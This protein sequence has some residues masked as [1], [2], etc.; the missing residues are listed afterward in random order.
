MRVLSQEEERRISS[1]RKPDG[2]RLK[3]YD[4]ASG[5]YVEI[6][7]DFET[8]VLLSPV[9]FRARVGTYLNALTAQ[10]LSSAMDDLRREWN[11]ERKADAQAV[12]DGYGAVV[13]TYED[14]RATML[15]LADG[16]DD[17]VEVS[18][19]LAD[20][21]KVAGQTVDRYESAQYERAVAS[22]LADRASSSSE[23]SELQTELNSFIQVLLQYP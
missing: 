23:P 12:M 17:T 13:T 11:E 14:I 6:S 18:K 3:Y 8:F 1:K 20:L 9:G 22:I 19:L 21:S 2:Q 4:A 7:Y 5:Q 15:E 10:S 16:F